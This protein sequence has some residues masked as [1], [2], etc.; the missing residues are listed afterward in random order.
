MVKNF[1]PWTVFQNK[2][3]AEIF[4]IFSLNFVIFEKEEA[5]Q[6]SQ[7][8]PF[9]AKMSRFFTE[10]LLAKPPNDQYKKPQ[11]PCKTDQKQ[12]PDDCPSLDGANNRYH[13]IASN[14]YVLLIQ[15]HVITVFRLCQHLFLTKNCLVLR[16]RCPAR[17]S[18]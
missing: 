11:T 2:K 13:F 18:K 10:K 3:W 8:L 9:W 1:C 5:L 12:V 16:R 17:P 4:A 15:N 6:K 7:N 14:P